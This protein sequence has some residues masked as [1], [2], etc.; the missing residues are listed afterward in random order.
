M[1]RIEMWVIQYLTYP[2][3][4]WVPAIAVILFG[5]WMVKRF[6]KIYSHNKVIFISV[7]FRIRSWNLGNKKRVASFYTKI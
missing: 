1:K 5:G 4:I 6:I 3:L 2:G 7:G